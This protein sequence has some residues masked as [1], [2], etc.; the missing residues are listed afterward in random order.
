RI[1]ES[2]RVQDS[3]KP[4]SNNVVG[5]SIVNMVEHNNS[6]KYNNNKGKRLIIT[7]RQNLLVGNVAKPFTLKGNAKVLML[8]TKPWIRH[9]GFSGWF[10]QLTERMMMLRGG[11]TQEQQFMCAKIDVGSRPMSRCM[12]DLFFT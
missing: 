1:E 12:M 6:S 2:L 8:A 7:R 3:D 10:I 9:T 4:K 11:L 5:P